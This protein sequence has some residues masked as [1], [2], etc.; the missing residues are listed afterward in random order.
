[1]PKSQISDN[2]QSVIIIAIFS[3]VAIDFHEICS[4]SMKVMFTAICLI[5]QH[6]SK[7]QFPFFLSIGS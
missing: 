4:I 1:M 6:L 5:N 3:V 2:I 7:Y